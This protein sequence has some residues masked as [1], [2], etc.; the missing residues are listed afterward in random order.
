[1]RT[2]LSRSGATTS[3]TYDARGRMDT[4]TYTIPGLSGS[5][6]FNWDHDSADRVTKLTYPS[7]EQVYATYDAAWRPTHACFDI[8]ERSSLRAGFAPRAPRDGIMRGGSAPRAPRRGRSA[9]PN[10]LQS[11]L[12]H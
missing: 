5:R 7:G 8:C 11:S 10:P 1:M 6:A 12:P 3:W 2:T 9:P 4:A